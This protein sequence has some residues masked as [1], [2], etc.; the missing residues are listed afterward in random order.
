MLINI[1]IVSIR[2][3]LRTCNEMVSNFIQLRL[4]IRTIET[5]RIESFIYYYVIYCIKF[6]SKSDYPY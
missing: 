1:L 2:I 6:E 5:Y 4:I 3:D